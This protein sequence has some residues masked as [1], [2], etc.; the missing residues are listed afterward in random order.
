MELPSAVLMRVGTLIAGCGN[1]KRLTIAV[2]WVQRYCDSIR[3]ATTPSPFP[4]SV[5]RFST[6]TEASAPA[7]LV[8]STVNAISTD[9]TANRT[10][11]PAPSSW[12]RLSCLEQQQ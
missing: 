11:L 9:P 2:E 6:F 7:V 1:F 3:I 5:N 12:A 4:P 10:S 8:T